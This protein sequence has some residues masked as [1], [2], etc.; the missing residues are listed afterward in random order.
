[1]GGS[2]REGPVKGSLVDLGGGKIGVV[3]EVGL[4][5]NGMGHDSYVR[6]RVPTGVVW[7]SR[8]VLTPTK[9][10]GWKLSHS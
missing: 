1:V 5:F 8:E 6:I 9:S 3:E 7:R 2:G 4:T 10:G